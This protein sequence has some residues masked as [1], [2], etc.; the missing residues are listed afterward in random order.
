VPGDLVWDADYYNR[1]MASDGT[2]LYWSQYGASSGKIRRY[3]LDGSAAPDDLAFDLSAPT[4]MAV[5]D[6]YVYFLAKGTTLF[7]L[8]KTGGVLPEIVTSNTG[9]MAYIDLV[10]DKYVWGHNN[11]S[12]GQIL[13]T[14]K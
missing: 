9:N 5:D 1:D 8:L 14:P 2:Y 6:T 4:G 10:D 11:N 13:R 7:R 3:P 12:L